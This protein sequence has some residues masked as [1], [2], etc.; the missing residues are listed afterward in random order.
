[1]QPP[2]ASASLEKIGQKRRWL[3]FLGGMLAGGGVIVALL[4]TPAVQGWL[5]KR[6]IAAQPGWRLDFT[7]FSAGPNGVRADGVDFAMPGIE[8]R[9]EPLRVQIA[10]TQLLRSRQL[11]IEKVQAQKVRLI[12]TPEKFATSAPTP[13]LPFAGLLPLLQLPVSWAVDRADLDGQIT[14]NEGGASVVVGDFKIQGGGLAP[15]QRGEFTYEL[16]FNSTLLPLAPDNHVRSHGTVHLT[17]TGAHGIARIELNGELSLPAYGAL[18]LPGAK[19]HLTID[20][21][22]PNEGY[23]LELDFGEAGRFAFAGSIDA[24]AAKL[25][26]TVEWTVRDSLLAG[27]S[28]SPLPAVFTEGTGEVALD[29]ESIDFTAKLQGRFTGKDWANYLPELAP[30]PGFTGDWSAALARRGAQLR[31]DR[32]SSR[33]ESTDGSAE[34]ALQLSAPVD[35]LKLPTSPVATFTV[36]GLPVEW[37]NPWLADSEVSVHDAAFSGQ[38][39]VAIDSAFTAH[40]QSIERAQATGIRVEG[41]PAPLVNIDFPSTATINAHAFSLQ[42]PV[43]QID[44]AAGDKVGGDLQLSYDFNTEATAIDTRMRGSLPSLFGRDESRPSFSLDTRFTQHGDALR[45]ERLRL[46]LLDGRNASP[47]FAMVLHHPLTLDMNTWWPVGLPAAP[48]ELLQMEFR[49]FA[50]DWAGQ[51]TGG[52]PVVGTIASGGST[53]SSTAEGKLRLDTPK[54]WQTDALRLGDPALTASLTVRPEATIAPAEKLIQATFALGANLPD[55]PHSKDTFGPLHAD[56]QFS[57]QNH[58]NSLVIID[59]L[60]FGVS[61]TAGAKALVSLHADQPFIAGLSDSGTAVLSTLAPLKLSLGELPLAWLQPWMEGIEISGTLAPAEWLIASQ[62]TRL[63]LRPTRPLAIE[64]LNVSSDGVELLR[65]ADVAFYPGLDLTLICTTAPEFALGFEGIARMDD[66]VVKIAGRD[67][68]DLDVALRFLGDDTKVLPAGIELTSRARLSAWHELAWLQK[69]GLP[70]AGTLVT[71]INGSLLGEAPV[72]FWT[73]LS[74]VK[75]DAG[76]EL[77][78]LEISARGKVDGV[79]R[80]VTG[81]VQVMLETRPQ[82]SDA[83]F[84]AKLDLREANLHI[85]SALTSRYL[86]AAAMMNL[87]DA[88]TSVP[89]AADAP[90]EAVASRA[91]ARTTSSGGPFW[92]VLRGAFDLNVGTVE[93][94]PYRIDQVTGRLTLGDDSAVI[95]NLHGAMFAGEWSGGARIDYVAD[96]PAGD[97]HLSGAFNIAQFQSARVVQTVFPDNDLASLDALINVEATVAAQG[98]RLPDLLNQAE[99][100]FEADGSQGLVRLKVPKQ[101]LV[102]TAAVFGGTVLLS[103]ELRALGRLLKKFSEM[104]V[105]TLRITG[106]RHRSGEIVLDAFRFESPQARLLGRGQIAADDGAPLMKRPLMLSLDLAAK[107]ETAVILGGMKLLNKEIDGAGF[108]GL[109][110]PLVLRG[111]AGEPDTRPLYDMLA[112]AVSGSKG[113]WGFLMRKVQAEVL[114]AQPVANRKTADTP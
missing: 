2:R 54:A 91:P 3:F 84:A 51:W 107:D 80:S 50:L 83:A 27:A 19:V 24:A 77:A 101:D 76:A 110:D 38:W 70:G 97:H 113:T 56:L 63:Q 48:T 25:L 33:A 28:D 35:L 29:L 31:L 22:Q 6:Y 94:A 64:N 57:A 36:R 42:A 78:P 96:D 92:S 23:R 68:L 102:A 11:R 89:A 85:A 7:R 16:S 52:V 60:E 105:E 95:S 93:F 10:P 108:R 12:I 30:V 32:F 9:T 5:L 41:F 69:Q 53:L 37:A 99:A 67:A 46:E 103:P 100:R 71:R 43:L 87:V 75:T 13:G 106:A 90:V 86:D 26:G 66:G 14:L 104:P 21:T 109:K 17:Q 47:S 73:R 74:G 114:K 8:A 45:V 34:I 59:A 18:K 61:Q 15:A 49:A 72:E 112:R 79:N 111:P 62:V 65:Q 81:D 98:N 44:S 1:M 20:G 55:W 58:G 39:N 40:F 4:F 88:F 82:R